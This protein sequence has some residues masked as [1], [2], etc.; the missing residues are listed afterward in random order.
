LPF[1]DFSLDRRSSG[2]NFSLAALFARQNE[3]PGRSSGKPAAGFPPQDPDM[4]AVY[5]AFVPVI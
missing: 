5:E 1:K 2:L 4:D 3:S